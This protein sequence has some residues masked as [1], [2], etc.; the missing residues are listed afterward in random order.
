MNRRPAPWRSDPDRGSVTAFFAIS[1]LGLL[2]LL[3]LV[4]D[5]GAKLRATQQATAIAAEAA[6]AGGQALDTAAATAGSSGHVDRTQAVQA[7]QHYLSA[8]GATGTVEVST[9]RTRLTV[10]VTRSAPT[11]FLS[12]IGIDQLTVTAHAQAVLVVAITGG[13]T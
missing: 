9:D 13:G 4:A 10:T 5:G 11:A 6:R 12:L 2:V 1:A 7:A 8:A 3:G